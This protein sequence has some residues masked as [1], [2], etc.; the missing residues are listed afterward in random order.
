[1]PECESELRFSSTGAVRGQTDRAKGSIELLGLNIKDLR[2]AR[3]AVIDVYLSDLK[4]ASSVT[5]GDL[6]SLYNHLTASKNN[7]LD[8][9]SPIIIN[10][11]NKLLNKPI[12][13]GL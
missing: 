5:R 4:T 11:L 6:I 8:E 7:Q 1:M 2:D 9:F 10:I 12:E 13:L 3:E